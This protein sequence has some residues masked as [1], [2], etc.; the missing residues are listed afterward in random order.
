MN[1]MY[2]FTASDYCATG[3]G[4]TICLLITRAYPRAEDYES[5]FHGKIKE[6][7]TPKFIAAREFAEEFGGWMT[8]GAENLPYEEFMNRHANHLPAYLK[9]LLEDDD[10]PGNLHF[11]QRF[12]LNFS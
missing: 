2:Q 4:R 5:E 1:N 9:N 10:Q 12:H 6:G 11:C 3:E 8:R 7:H